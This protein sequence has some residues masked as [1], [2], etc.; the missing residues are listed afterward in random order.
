MAKL[1]AVKP[2]N[3]G[4]VMNRLSS[5]FKNRSGKF[6]LLSCF[7]CSAVTAFCQKQRADSLAKLLAAEK[8]DTGRV[9]IMWQLASAISIYNP[10]TALELS[11]QAL[12][13]ARNINY[14]EGQSRSLGILANT[15]MKIGNYP[16]A[17]ELNLQKL[18]LEEK[19]NNPHNLASVLMNTGI[20][21]VLQDEYRKALDYYTIA[22][23]VITKHNV[24]ALKF[25]IAINT[26]D[27]Y[28]RLNVSDSAYLY[29]NKSLELA[30]KM[31]DNDFIG[32]SMTGLGHSYRKLENY[33]ASLSNYQQA[34]HF[35]RLAND[36]E[37]LC[38]A[39]LGLAN[40]YR[41]MNKYD[42]AGRYAN[43]SFSIAGKGGFISK[44]L[45]AAKFL[46]AHYK[47]VRSIDSAFTYADYVQNL[48]DSVNGKS[49]IRESQILS[50]NEHFRQMEV[51]ENKRIA[52]EKRFQQ[53]QLL[54][55]GIFIPGFFLLTVLLSRAKI[56]IRVIR[57]LGVLSLLFLFEYLTLL[58]H[59]TV[60]AFTN[61]TPVL[62]ILIFVIIAAILIPAHHRL[63]HWMIQKLIH[64][65]AHHAGHI[66]APEILPAG[67][68]NSPG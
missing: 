52:E 46:M 62:E 21:Y 39:A 34:I 54:L 30:K 17:L 56:H 61:H 24:E 7:L 31:N 42:S 59:P 55:I 57:L 41:T 38:E 68:K 28:D 37:L 12:F 10:D 4:P 20:V 36:D 45:D 23:S 33:P 63:E 19:R 51:E 58:L 49:K 11:Q 35:L 16:R 9:K 15:F 53:L 32:A 50:S 40:L 26:G 6:I 1:E 2:F 18:Q 13:L 48:N 64:H 65:R 47:Q 60:A 22:D 29:F 43:L 67:N 8:T 27:A 44:E 5:S 66:E 25:N 14:T 3:T